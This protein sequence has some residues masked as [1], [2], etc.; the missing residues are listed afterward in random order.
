MWKS[1]LFSISDE[2]VYPK[3]PILASKIEFLS[4]F[5]IT[6]KMTLKMQH[7]LYKKLKFL[8][9]SDFFIFPGTINGQWSPKALFCENVQ[10]KSNLGKKWTKWPKR[11]KYIKNAKFQNF[12]QFCLFCGHFDFFRQFGQNVKK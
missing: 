6:P 9:F 10:K 5:E 8:V 11:Q 12:G 1:N 4:I 3:S 2:L 7:F